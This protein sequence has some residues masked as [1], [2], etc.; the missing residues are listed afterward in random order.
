VYLGLKV[1]HKDQVAYKK[2]K[3]ERTWQFDKDNIASKFIAGLG[4]RDQ[5]SKCIVHTL[6]VHQISCLDMLEKVQKHEKHEVDLCASAPG[7]QP[8]KKKQIQENCCKHILIMLKK[9]N[10]KKH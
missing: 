9:P 5:T 7:S 10:W 8:N 3:L 6:K 2:L 4:K 1:H